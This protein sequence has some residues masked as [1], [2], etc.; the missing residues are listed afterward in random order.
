MS[1][2]DLHR[3]EVAGGSVDHGGLR[4][5]HR[6]RAIVFAPQSDGCD[7]FVHKPG[8]L[9]R[10][11]RTTAIQ[12]TGEHVVICCAAAALQPSGKASTCISRDFELH[13]PTGLL[14]DHHSARPNILPG[15]ETPDPQLHEVAAPQLA[16]DG[17]VKQ[18]AIP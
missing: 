1:E 15:Y 6:V 12:S 17:K 4:S 7:P 8:I 14:L 2:Q 5:P 3:P 9:P 18:R 11:H 10:A 13:R 16:I